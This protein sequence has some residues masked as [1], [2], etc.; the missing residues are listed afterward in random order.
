MMDKTNPPSLHEIKNKLERLTKIDK[1]FKGY[2]L[3][4]DEINDFENKIEVRLPED[5]RNFLLEIGR[6]MGPCDY[7][8]GPGWIL[9][10]LSCSDYGFGVPGWPPKPNQSFPVGRQYIESL[11]SDDIGQFGFHL[12]APING[13]IPI[14]QDGLSFIYLITVGELKGTVLEGEPS[15]DRDNQA[16]WRLVV[17]PMF[18][19]MKIYGHFPI[20]YPTLWGNGPANMP[21]FLDWYNTWLDLYLEDLEIQEIK[22]RLE[23]AVSRKNQYLVK[24]LFEIIG[25][26][27]IK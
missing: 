19:R 4:V 7:L 8:L 26:Y 21:T 14:C 23:A 17:V 16:F 9:D 2:P 25:K 12:P 13:C 22:Q 3:L 1:H 24:N 18:H 20:R 11:R 15:G 5:Y 27:L 6:V 10:E